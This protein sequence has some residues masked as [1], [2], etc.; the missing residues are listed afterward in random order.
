MRLAVS[1]VVFNSDPVLF[2]T[3]LESL[4]AAVLYGKSWQPSLTVSLCIVE[5]EHVERRN[6]EQVRELIKQSRFKGFDRID[7]KSVGVNLGYGRGHNLAIRSRESDFHLVLNPDVS[8]SKTALYEG[9]RYLLEHPRVAL[10]APRVVDCNGDDLF[11]CKR[12]PSLLD[13]ALRGF[14]PVCIKRLFARRLNQYEMRELAGRREPLAG[15]TIVSGCYMLV[16]ADAMGALAGFDERFFL[17]FEDFDLSLRIRDVGEVVYLPAMKIVH[18]GGHA[19][20]K[21]LRHICLFAQSAW[22][23]YQRHGWRWF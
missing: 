19:A 23:F 1:V 20:Q 8:V 15:I 4:E 3:T 2:T 17:Y 10:V 11:P 12:Y 21:G 13:L 22:K 7:L 9:L 18:Y 16:R 14:A 6:L 5:N